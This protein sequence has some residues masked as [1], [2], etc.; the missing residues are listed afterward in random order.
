MQSHASLASPVQIGESRLFVTDCSY[1]GKF[2][3]VSVLLEI[4]YA[5]DSFSVEEIFLTE[6]A[7]CKM[8]PGVY[9]DNHIFLHNNGR[10]TTMQCLD[11]SGKAVWEGD[12]IPGF[13]LGGYILIDDKIIIQNGKNGDIHLLEANPEAYVEL[14]KASYFSAKKSQAWAP[15]AFSQGKLIIRNLQKM[16][17]VDLND[18]E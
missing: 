14:G 10:P 11:L 4:D 5:E 2:D 3:P 18:L 13:E 16:V 15:L 17:C 8:H 9:Y 12:S 7:G 6:E 1:N